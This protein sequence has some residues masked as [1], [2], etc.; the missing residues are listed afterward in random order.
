MRPRTR[1][2][3]TTEEELEELRAE[4]EDLKA[5]FQSRLGALDRTIASLQAR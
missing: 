2:P 1:T 4:T 3:R 5:E